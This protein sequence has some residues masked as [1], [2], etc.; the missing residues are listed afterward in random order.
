MK[1]TPGP[2]EV[3]DEAC[4]Y[5]PGGC[6]VAFCDPG[7]TGLTWD[8]AL[9]NATL[10]S[11]APDLFSMLEHVE[12][13]YTALLESPKVVDVLATEIFGMRARVRAALAK[14]RGES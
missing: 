7:T 13:H 3:D 4:V 6:V 14:A 5:G 1:H 9:D 2:W 8:E 11:S 12:R 10:I